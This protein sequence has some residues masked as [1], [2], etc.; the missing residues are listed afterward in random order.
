MKSNRLVVIIFSS[1][2]L[3]L[4][5]ACGFNF[6]TAK[7]SDAYMARELDNEFEKVQSYG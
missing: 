3:L 5:I 4:T 2:M 7:V 6:S 1:M